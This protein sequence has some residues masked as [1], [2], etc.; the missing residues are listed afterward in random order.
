VARIVVVGA[1]VAGLA[2]AARLAKLR[3]D[4]VVLE[5]RSRVGGAVARVE[6][7]GFAW[8][9]GPSSTLLPAVIRDLFRKSGRPLER[10]VDLELRAVARRHV[11]ADGA[12]V[13]LPTGSRGAQTRAVDAGLGAGAGAD[14]TAFVDEQADTWQA[15]RRSVLDD[16]DGGERLRD[17]PV[18]A[19]LGG[20]AS[21]ARLLKR[22]FRDERLRLMAGA[23]FE[24]N[25]SRLRDVPR[26]GSVEPYVERAFGVWRPSGGMADLVEALAVRLD[27]RRV[28]TRLETPV[29]R[30]AW[31]ARAGRIVAV[32]TVDGL[33]VPADIVVSS[34]DPRRLFGELLDE[35]AAPQARRAFAAATP[36]LP[37]A[38]VHLGLSGDVPALPEE[39]VLH[40][41][42]LLVVHTGG[43]APSGHHAWTVHRRGSAGEDIV[44]SLARRGIDVRDQVVARVDR[45]PSDVIA[46]VGGSPYGIAWDGYR[47][48]ARRAALVA[49]LPGLHLVGASVHPGAGVAFAAWG[50][51]HAAERIGRA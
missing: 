26:F 18:V 4:V 20:S 12:V 41:D 24:L 33:V 51:A 36:A 22:R 31:D 5:Q 43:Q 19:A 27:E 21:L 46:E 38:I 30:L 47:A 6:S 11:F 8:D 17:R 45:S 44:A 37:P 40:G 9:S 15:L 14:W 39:V 48:Y 32:E 25:G 1:G 34:V 42:P 7:D 50:A 35:K 10:Y 29:A 49:P 13:D 3:H 28:D 16:P 23:S 2:A